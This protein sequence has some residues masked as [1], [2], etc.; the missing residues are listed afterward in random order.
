[1]IF[2]HTYRFGF[3]S[4]SV[5]K[6]AIPNHFVPS[7]D[8]HS[9]NLRIDIIH[10]AASLILAG[11][12]II[13]GCSRR[14]LSPAQRGEVVYRTDCISCHNRDPNQPG[15]LGPAVAGASRA[16]LQ[17][18]LLHQSYPPGYKPERKS[19]LMRA[20]PWLEPHID[21]LT[22]YLDAMAKRPER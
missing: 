21:D 15:S 8:L 6:F 20:M 14:P 2:G 9:K 10:C 11:A 4:H 17:A 3:V 22:A 5:S 12:L 18:R 7:L 19:H 13:S 16:L 1:V